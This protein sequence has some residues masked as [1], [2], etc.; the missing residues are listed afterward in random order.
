MRFSLA[1]NAS[2]VGTTG[3]FSGNFTKAKFIR[4]QSCSELELR[5]GY[6]SG[7]LD[8]G[9]WL[10]FALEKPDPANF[11]F[12][13]YTHFSGARIGDP[14]IGGERASVEAELART[15][16]GSGAVAEA[17]KRH[18]DDLQLI[19]PDRLAK[20][21]PVAPGTEYPVGS[22]IYQCNIPAPI[23]C[24]IAAFVGPG[25]TYQGSYS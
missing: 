7:R 4:G 20:I 18:V 17:K 13:G 19:G 6:G 5:V 15:L 16:G 25:E 21:I 11:E 24:R 12:G 3:K 14:R 1:P 22:G 10:L 8:H 9:Y 23:S 2:S